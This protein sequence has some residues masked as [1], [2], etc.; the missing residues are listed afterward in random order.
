[1]EETLARGG[2]EKAQDQ[3]KDT[4][5]ADREKGKEPVSGAHGTCAESP[6]ATPQW[7]SSPKVTNYVSVSVPH[8]CLL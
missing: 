8:F 2:K 3:E 4:V 6:R 7:S 5:A 1:M